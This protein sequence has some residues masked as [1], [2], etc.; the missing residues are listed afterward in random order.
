[1]EATSTDARTVIAVVDGRRVHRTTLLRVLRAA[2]ELGIAL[3]P[4]GGA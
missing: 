3:P 1:V 2:R 4:V